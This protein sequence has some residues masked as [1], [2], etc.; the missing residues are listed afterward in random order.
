MAVKSSRKD[1]TLIARTGG[2]IDGAN[3]REF[4]VAL[5]EAIDESDTKVILDMENLTYISSAGLRVI[6]MTAKTLQKQ[7]A[8]FAICTLAPSIQE[9]FRISGFDRIIPIHE[10]LDAA[11]TSLQ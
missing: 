9:V 5:E 3:A 10:S 2:R 4:H 1:G 8:K 6:L 7:K 11:I